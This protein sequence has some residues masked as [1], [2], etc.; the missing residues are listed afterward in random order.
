METIQYGNQIKDS[1]VLH[2]NTQ[3]TSSIILNGDYKS[4]V[5][6]DLRSYLD[7]ENDES[8]DYVTV[9]IPH[10][11]MTNSNY[12]INDYNNII[13]VLYGGV[14]NTYTISQGNYIKSTFVSYLQTSGILPTTLFT[15]TSSSVTN[16]FTITVTALFTSTY[17]AGST[18]GFSSGTTCDYI[19][20][21][22]TEIFT[23]T[24]AIEMPRSMNFLPI[25]RFLFHANILS[26]GLVL[27]TNST[28]GAS[29]I[30]CA[31]PNLAKL[32]SQIIY[33]NYGG[34]FLVN[35]QTN[36]SGLLISIT[37]DDNRLINFNGISCYFDIRF[38]IFRRSIQRPLRFSS[39]VKKIQE[40]KSN[41][42]DAVIIEE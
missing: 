41:I 39:L 14:V 31:V 10:V 4:K 26:N 35:S 13:K 28:V 2:L 29:D 9:T 25:P 12:I 11:V 37:D 27:T 22:R 23:T 38:N 33:E 42:N 5:F 15:I 18:W 20:G 34:E 16:R 6:Y 40:T 7:F 32:N 21:F 24:T 3:T 19:F 17:G 30:L 36:M 8:I 1:L